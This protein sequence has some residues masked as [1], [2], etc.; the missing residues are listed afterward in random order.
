MLQAV[1]HAAGPSG[2]GGSGDRGGGG[3][4]TESEPS[5]SGGSRLSSD[6]GASSGA[7]AN[8]GLSGAACYT[9]C[10]SKAKKGHEVG[11]KILIKCKG[12]ISW[13]AMESELAAFKQ[14]GREAGR[15]GV[16]GGGSSKI[17]ARRLD[18]LSSS[19]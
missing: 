4:A 8:G 10:L 9:T 3:S 6:L 11:Q 13:K 17:T 18:F 1:L 14:Q 5:A 2:A 15:S 19:S 16:C 12:R 7:R